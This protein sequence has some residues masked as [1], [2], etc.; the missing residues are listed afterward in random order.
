MADQPNSVAALFPS[1]VEKFGINVALAL[2][3]FLNGQSSTASKAFSGA[4]LAGTGARIAG[5][6]SG[7]PAL[8]ALGKGIGSA[9]GLAS[10]G[11]GA[12]QA[13][14]DP[15]LNRTQQIGHSGRA[16]ADTLMGLLIP[17]Y[18]LAKSLSIVGQVLQGSGSPQVRGAGRALDQAA[19][20]AGAKA[21]WS[22]AQG[23]MSPKAALTK[24]GPEGFITDMLGPV[25]AILKGVGADKNVSRNIM[26]YGPIPFAG[27][28]LSMLGIGSKPTTGTMFRKD[29]GSIF[30]R[31]PA[32]KGLDT[33]KYT[34]DP[35]FYNSLPQE[36]RDRATAYSQQLASLSSNAKS[37]PQ[38]YQ[39]QIAAMLLNAY[40]A[41]LP[42]NLI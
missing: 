29:V 32:L 1:L 39:N 42:Q 21:F 4:S 16:V 38:A 14:T 37:N 31:I 36:I 34:I 28:A 7:N 41:N 5:G 33:S 18:G 25:G 35:G 10:G 8:S 13:A 20:P 15:S 11:Y 3:P 2:L 24:A 40:G 12:Y 17:Y 26:D 22:V 6:L 19:E 30:D 27:K 23:D 9:L